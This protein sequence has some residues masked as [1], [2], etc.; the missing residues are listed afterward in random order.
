MFHALLCEVKIILLQLR[1]RNDDSEK[2]P[3][4]LALITSWMLRKCEVGTGYVLDAEE[5]CGCL[6][7]LQRQTRRCCSN[8]GDSRVLSLTQK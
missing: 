3:L 4:K 2:S 7:F 1:E 8:A 5:V 6:A